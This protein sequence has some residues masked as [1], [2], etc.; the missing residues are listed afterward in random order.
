MLIQ[1]LTASSLFIP[2]L[3]PFLLALHVGGVVQGEAVLQRKGLF[4]AHL[5]LLRV[6]Y[7]MGKREDKMLGFTSACPPSLP[8]SLPPFLPTV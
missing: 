4:V 2:V 3:L 7:V 1:V 8:P 6:K 5:L